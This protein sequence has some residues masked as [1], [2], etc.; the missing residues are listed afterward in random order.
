MPAEP[1]ACTNLG[2]EGLARVVSGFRLIGKALWH[3]S[4]RGCPAQK[5][6]RQPGFALGL[7][8]MLWLV[9]AIGSAL[10]LLPVTSNPVWAATGDGASVQALVEKDSVSVG[11]PL[12]LQIRVEGGDITP[13]TDPPD[14]SAVVDFIVESLGGRSNNSSSITIVNGKMSKVESF[15][16]V[17]AFRLTP[18]KVGKL[19]IPAIAVPVDAAKSR[20]LRTEPITIRVAEPEA[21]DDF[22]LELKFSKT[23]FYIGEP[24]ILTFVWYIGKEVQSA[25][26]NLPI[27][28]DE[29]FAFTD[30]KVDQNPNKQVFQIPLGGANVLADKGAVVRNG[31]EFTTLSFRKVLFAKQAGTF[32]VPEATVSC[33]ALVG[34]SRQ[35]QQRGPFNRFFDDDFFNPGGRGV[36]KTFVARSQPVSL[37]V[38]PLPEQG[39][40]EPFTGCVGQF[41]VATAASP[42]EV[43]IGDPITLSVSISGSEYLDHV[44]LPALAQDPAYERDFKIPEERAAGV[45]RGN[46]KEFTQTLR[47]KSTDVTTIPPV[48][49]SY[50]NPATGSYEIAQ[51]KP[52][53]LTVRPAKVL[54]SADVEGRSEEA[55]VK[56]NELEN[57]SK[58]IAYNY[59][60][61]EVL[62]RQSYR[63][64]TIARSPLWLALTCL[65]LLA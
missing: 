31:K 20:I 4:S 9:W 61:A 11:E 21:T 10:G 29:A 62:E 36:Y 44:E 33:N 1:Q 49:F 50:F 43:S 42:L 56:R 14:T 55:A 34:Y 47:A 17:Y 18:K 38:A 13:G 12:V 27:L 63:I 53:G 48:R 23:S 58:G 22:H 28:Q 64:S 54:T 60:G 7:A 26:F 30:P 6:A 24:V 2:T 8:L 35:P 3:P 41:Q 15:G 5:K 45:V 16:H 65:P 39:K 52:I 46:A 37:T 25:N 51:S 57:W 32:A 19:E 59:E 40:P